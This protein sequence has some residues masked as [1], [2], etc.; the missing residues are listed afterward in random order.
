MSQISTIKKVLTTFYHF[1]GIERVGFVTELNEVIEVQNVSDKPTEGFMVSAE[2]IIECTENKK[3]WATWHTHPNQSSNL[4]GE[5]YRMFKAWPNM[6]H[7]I[8]GNDGVKAFK[9]DSK[10]DAILEVQ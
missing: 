1:E 10:I 8:S 2:D 5:D 4:S 9:Y 6:V 3:S 7:F